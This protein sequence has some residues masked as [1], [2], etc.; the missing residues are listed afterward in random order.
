[1]IS[2]ELSALY[3]L[4]HT[5]AMNDNEHR[6]KWNIDDP[7]EYQEGDYD[8]VDTDCKSTEDAVE[9]LN[10]VEIALKALAA[11]KP[12]FYRCPIWLSYYP[13]EDKWEMTFEPE[14][15]DG[16]VY[17][18]LSGHGKDTYDSLIEVINNEEN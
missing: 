4:G 9:C 1:M 7:A 11:L 12:L 8:P 3:K 16:L 17:V 14:E 5:I 15:E 6:I 2:K 10:T 18:L 13:K